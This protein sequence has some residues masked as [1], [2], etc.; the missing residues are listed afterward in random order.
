MK[1]E[2]GQGRHPIADH[3]GNEVGGWQVGK[4]GIRLALALPTR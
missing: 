1:G 4:V 2:V 3:F